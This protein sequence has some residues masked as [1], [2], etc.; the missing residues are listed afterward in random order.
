MEIFN[1]VIQQL[2]LEGFQP[3]INLS[4]EGRFTLKQL[5]WK[6]AAGKEQCI[7]ESD[8]AVQADKLAWFQ[9][10]KDDEHLLKVYENGHSFSWEP[11]TY[12]P[13]FGCTCLL[14][15]WYQDHLLFVYQEKHA[16]YICVVKDAEVRHFHFIGG[17]MQ[18]KD[19]LISFETYMDKIPG[20]VRVIRIPE[21]V[22]EE[23]IDMAEAERLGLV[24]VGIY[25]VGGIVRE[26]FFS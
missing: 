8:I 20:K 1:A 24:P 14:L 6:D 17:N 25:D 21:L 16:I 22:E 9:T 3:E 18:R 13:V 23:P 15:E 11:E 12:N 2:Q 19:D 26:S 4:E 10:N 7:D 5:L